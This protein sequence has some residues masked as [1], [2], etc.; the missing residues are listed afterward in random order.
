[1]TPPPSTAGQSADASDLASTDTSAE[2]S[3]REE[4][5]QEGF[6]GLPVEPQSEAIRRL[7]GELQEVRDQH[8][9][10]AAE[11]DNY[12]KRVARERSE[13]TERAEGA[14]VSRLLDALDDMDRLTAT[15]G[16]MP[17]EALREAVTLVDRKFWKQLESAGLQRIDPVGMTFDPT[18]HEAVSIIPP[19]APEQ[20][21][22][23]A[24]TFQT[25]YRF[26]GMLIRPARVQV[27]SEQGQA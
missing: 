24:S 15:M 13:L 4:T 11:F 2:P 21:H 5:T 17:S 3:S 22:Q 6:G 10:L 14:V 25:G 8:L 7:E 12:R 26:K 23:V 16:S 1:M 27:Y 9:R 20:D 18:E 19:P